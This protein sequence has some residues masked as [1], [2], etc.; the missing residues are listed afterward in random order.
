M[1]GQPG[2]AATRLADQAPA[3]PAVHD[4]QR[5]MPTRGGRPLLIRRE[6]APNLVGRLAVGVLSLAVVL[7][8]SGCPSSGHHPSAGGSSGQQGTGPATP[9]PPPSSFSLL[10]PMVVA[11]PSNPDDVPSGPP[12]CGG[13]VPTPLS[14]SSDVA[15]LV[16]GCGGVTANGSYRSYLGWFT[17][18][19]TAVL[20]VY[21][22]SPPT[23]WHIYYP[24]ADLGLVPFTWAAAETYVQTVAEQHFPA[25]T[26]ADLVPIGGSI[27]LKANTPVQIQVRADPNATAESRAGQLLIHYVVDNLKEEV[28]R[29]SIVSYTTAI[30]NCVNAAYNQ[31]NSLNQEDSAAIPDTI[32]TTLANY[33]QCKDLQEKLKEDPASELHVAEV[34][35]IST[36][37]LLQNLSKVGGEA[38][39][40]NWPSIVAELIHDGGRFVE[41]IHG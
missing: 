30:S 10:P 36:D 6:S 1:S 5:R 32:S 24:R 22:I 27:L 15:Q 14:V 26:G 23:Y 16:S 29:D 31:W 28:P 2:E 41:E 20:D 19:S 3:T 13:S 17:N 21:A 8:V 34:H 33:Q 25:P 40:D 39:Q 37:E 12:A 11:A 9:S 4:R 7:T 35:P 18:L 38:E